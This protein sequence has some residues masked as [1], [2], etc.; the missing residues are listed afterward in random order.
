MR[1]KFL[2]GWRQFHRI[3]RVFRH[4]HIAGDALHRNWIR[5]HHLRHQNPARRGHKG[6]G[7]EVIDADSHAGIG[8]KDGPRDA[9]HADG[10]DAEQLTGRQCRQI[11]PDD[12]RRFA[13]PDKDIRGSAQRFDAGNPRHLLNAAPDPA[14]DI[15]HHADVIEDGYE[16]GEE[17]DDGQRGNGKAIPANFRRCQRAE[18]EIRAILRKAQ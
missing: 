13:L 3:M 16:R 12:Q 10:H 8:G 2:L 18:N 17:N 1:S 15:L 11:G 9:R 5:H 14:D 7:E 4:I 6:S